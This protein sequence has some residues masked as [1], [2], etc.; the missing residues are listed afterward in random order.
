MWWALPYATRIPL[1]KGLLP[2]LLEALSVDGLQLSGS[3][4]IARAAQV[5]PLLGAHTQ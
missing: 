4:G 3:P 1:V 5:M 2:Q